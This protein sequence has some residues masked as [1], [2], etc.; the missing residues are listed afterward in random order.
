LRPNCAMNETVDAI[1]GLGL[2][3]RQKRTGHRVGLDAVLLAAAMGAPA[4]RIADVGA[5]VGAVGLALARRFAEASVDLV[6][7]DPETAAL[8]QENAGANGLAERARIAVTDVMDA[9]ARRAAGLTD[10]AADLVVTNPPFYAA[11]ETRVSPDRERARAHALGG[12]NALAE[13][14]WASLA[15]L[16][17]GGRFALIHRPEALP[18]IYAALGRRLG[19][20]AVRPIY[21][22]AQENAIRIIL[23]GVKGSGAP[24]RLQPG[25]ILH[26]ADGGA[27]PQAR[28]IHEGRATL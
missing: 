2:V 15:L 22:R 13:W 19:D 8:A 1:S 5:G 9:K 10:G 28:A 4:R 6:E 26:E 25:L 17:P 24:A 7:I 21:S 14:L 27:T 11:G 18:A 3:L 20:V 23:T 12:A 16:A